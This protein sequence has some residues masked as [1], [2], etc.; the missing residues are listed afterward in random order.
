MCSTL[1]FDSSPLTSGLR[2]IAVACALVLSSSSAQPRSAAD[3]GRFSDPNVL[4]KP[5]AEGA[6]AMAPPAAS[7]VTN[8]RFR[9]HLDH[10]CHAVRGGAGIDQRISLERD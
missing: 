6:K 8:P 4:L 5:V 10:Q 1:T 2:L 9:Q 7:P 3:D